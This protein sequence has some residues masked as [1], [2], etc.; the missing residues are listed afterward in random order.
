MYVTEPS[1]KLES[2]AMI[3]YK[4]PEGTKYEFY[5]TQ[6]AENGNI[7][8]NDTADCFKKRYSSM[9]HLLC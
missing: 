9:N 6:Y 4:H 1:W 3:W 5:F 7:H 8:V 2:D